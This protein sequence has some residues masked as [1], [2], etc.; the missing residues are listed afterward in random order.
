[1]PKYVALSDWTEQGVR[2]FNE[3]VDRQAAADKAFEGLGVSFTD[4]H[5]RLEPTIVATVEAPDDQSPAAALLPARS[6]ATSAR[7]LSGHS[8]ATRCAPSSARVP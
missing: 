8:R 2:N 7:R 1:M 4:V 5:W 3:T 6:K